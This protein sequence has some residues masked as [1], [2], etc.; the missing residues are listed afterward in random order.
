[1]NKR[2]SSA[3]L[4][5]AGL[6]FLTSMIQVYAQDAPTQQEVLDKMH[7]ANSYFM[8]IWTDPGADIVTDRARPS[9]IWTRA[10]YYEGLMT[11]YYIDP[12]QEYYDYAVQWS[13]SHNWAPA[14]DRPTR[15]ADNQCCGQT[16]I[17]LYLIDPKPERV[18]PIKQ[19]IDQM[20]NSSRSDDWWW[21][22]ALQMAMPVFAKLGVVFAD[23]KYFEK[24]FDLYNNTKT[25]Q[26]DSGLYN[27]VDHLW[28][29]DADFDPP[30][31]EPNGEDCYWSRGNGWA[32]TALA[33]VLD[34]L[35]EDAPHRDEY[36]TTFKEM[37]EALL[38][39]QRTD[40]FWNVSLHDPNNFGGKELTGTGFFT[41]GLAWG[42]N[43]GLLSE[44]EYKPAVIEAW[45]GM[46][47]DAL[48]PNGFLGYVQ[49][50]GKEPSSSQ[51]VT[52]DSVPNFEDFGLG[53]FLLAGAEV[54]KLIGNTTA[55]G[56]ATADQ[57]S[58]LPAKMV[59]NPAYPNPFNSS[60][61]ITYTLPD[62]AT[63]SLAVYDSLGQKV[64]TIVGNS[65]QS[66]GAHNASWNGADD[67]GQQVASG[68]YI[69]RLQ[70]GPKIKTRKVMLIR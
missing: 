16:Y 2:T 59:L 31:T 56:D 58:T 7:L 6:I 24:M 54:Y 50:T 13:Q 14:Y 43:N 62:E 28:W 69:V 47:N 65:R 17:E 9:N 67:G 61:A 46:A 60:T 34:V 45:N 33:R 20:V 26:G 66:A 49:G 68:I 39:I 57:S 51:P 21:V 22:D 37:A 63:V 44:E 52:Y 18:A 70:I 12:K 29:R 1:M 53:A 25:V 19:S 30:Y 41:Y 40:G 15:N 36:V 10:A 64:H 8:N 48:H 23:D 35:P 3:T 32:L 55:V 42:I 38:P 5:G 11:M 27:P 4:L